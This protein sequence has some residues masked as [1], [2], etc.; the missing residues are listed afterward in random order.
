MNYLMLDERESEKPK[1]TKPSFWSKIVKSN[2]LPSFCA[3]SLVFGLFCL[4]VNMLIKDNQERE[5]VEMAQKQIR[6]NTWVKISGNPKKLTQ[7]EYYSMI[8]NKIE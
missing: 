2:Y 1:E 6:F 5:K 7:E 3:F 4:F 8:E